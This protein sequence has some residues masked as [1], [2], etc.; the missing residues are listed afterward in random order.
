MSKPIRHFTFEPIGSRY[1][2]FY[3]DGEWIGRGYFW[4]KQYV[5]G[6]QHIGLNISEEH[7]GKG[8]SKILLRFIAATARGQGATGLTLDV[9]PDNLIAR[10]LYDKFGFIQDKSPF[11]DRLFMQLDF[12]PSP[13]SKIRVAIHNLSTTL[14]G[15]RS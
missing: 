14:K 8:Y 2:G 6:K 5:P 15:F 13:M 9:F 4:R 7:R 10:R 11:Y 12:H 1:Y 3:L